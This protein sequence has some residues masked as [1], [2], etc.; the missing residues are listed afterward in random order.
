MYITIFEEEIFL[1]LTFSVDLSGAVLPANSEILWMLFQI[2][3][4]L[5]IFN[6]LCV[7]VCVCHV[8]LNYLASELTTSEIYDQET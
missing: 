8:E 5:E 2:H 6:K 4:A 1:K 3:E 7:C